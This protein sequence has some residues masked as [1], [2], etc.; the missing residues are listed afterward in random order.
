MRLP[1]YDHFPATHTERESEREKGRQREKGYVVWEEAQL[2]C[3][4]DDGS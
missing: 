1:A 4:P 2:T 3:L